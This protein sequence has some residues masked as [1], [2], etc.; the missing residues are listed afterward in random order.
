MLRKNIKFN[1]NFSETFELVYGERRT[2]AWTADQ[3]KAAKFSIL[4][5]NPSLKSLLNIL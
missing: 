4:M 1:K 2:D 5:P 3:Y